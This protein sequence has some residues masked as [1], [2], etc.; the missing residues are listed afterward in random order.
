M[1]NRLFVYGTL[2]PGREN[3]GLLQSLPGRWRK[4]VVKGRLKPDG[5]PATGGYPALMLDPAGGDV[6]GVIL[7]SRRLPGYWR[8]L[9][10]F[11]GDGYRRVVTTATLPGGEALSVQVYEALCRD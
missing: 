5:C 3:E 11:E 10:A 9:D 4:A 1:I 8:Q 2:R 6:E 7:T